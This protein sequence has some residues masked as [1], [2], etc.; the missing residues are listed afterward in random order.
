LQFKKGERVASFNLAGGFAEYAAFPALTTF[1]IP[2]SLNFEEASTIPL[3][4]TTAALGIF[5]RLPFHLNDKVSPPQTIVVWGASGS[6]GNYAVQLSKL[7]GLRVIGVAG[8]GGPVARLAGADVVLDYR[9]RHV[10]AQIRHALNG[11]PLQY[12]FD[13]ISEGGTSEALASLIK[14][15]VQDARIVLV[16]S[17]S[18]ALPSH[19]QYPQASVFSCYGKDQKLGHGIIRGDPED[20]A[21]A[22]QFFERL[23]EWLREGKIRPNKVTIVPGG[24]TGI[25]DGF[26]RM[27]ERKI[28]GEKLVYCIAETPGL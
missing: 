4:I 6:V 7:I 23:E 13:A 26:R 16:L 17:P 12:A 19:I 10:T 15:D 14:P 1:H 22:I 28:S 2:D 24:L 21:F 25:P 3:A 20:K 9:T 27:K 5:R 11:E 18:R 8:A